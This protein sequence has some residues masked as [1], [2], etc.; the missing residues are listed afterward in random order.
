MRLLGIDHGI[1]RIGLAVSDSS[2]LIAREYRII[3]RKSKAEDFALINE[4]VEQ[5]GI[6]ALVV[7]LPTNFEAHEGQYSQADTVR[8]WV[9]RLTAVVDR[10]VVYWDE[11]LSSA[12]ARD[13]ARSKRRKPT[14]PIDDLAARIILQSYLDAVR[15][16]MAAPPDI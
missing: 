13:L 1:K 2:G 9:E 10:P 8:T 7:G 14:D 3:T 6:E 15:D 12:D 16:G 5:E 11:Q 4:I